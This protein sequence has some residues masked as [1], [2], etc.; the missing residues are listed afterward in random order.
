MF[1]D[2]AILDI[3]KKVE[4]IISRPTIESDWDSFARNL[5]KGYIKITHN[6]CIQKL[7]W[8]KDRELEVIFPLH[9]SRVK[10]VIF[11]AGCFKYWLPK[12]YPFFVRDSNVFFTSEFPKD[13]YRIVECDN[14]ESRYS[15]LIE[16]K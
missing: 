1:F 12:Q 9:T 2:V 6:R 11:C 14:A 7:I 4:D 16:V 3:N 10:G 8:A 13:L 5:G 15:K